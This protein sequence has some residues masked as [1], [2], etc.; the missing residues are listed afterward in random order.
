MIIFDFKS[1][2]KDPLYI[3]SSALL[4]TVIV[5]SVALFFGAGKSIQTGTSSA[6]ISSAS[7]DVSSE[8][9]S[10]A[11]EAEKISFK[12]T[13][14]TANSLTVTDSFYV[15]KG[16]CNPA[17]TLYINGKRITPAADGSFSCDVDLKVGKN[18]ITVQHGS[19][20]TV[21]NITYR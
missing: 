9:S 1:I 16:T 2:L 18:A 7:G 8:T 13:S 10:T 17:D 12:V 4:C 19:D 6:Y 5:L 11:S 20:K 3:A 14:P 15:F 21:Y